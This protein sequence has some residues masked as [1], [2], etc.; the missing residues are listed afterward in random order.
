MNQVIPWVLVVA[1]W[2]STGL[3]KGFSCGYE[4]RGQVI[5]LALVTTKGLT[6]KWHSGWGMG[7][8]RWEMGDEE[9]N[10]KGSDVL[11]P[12]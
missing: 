4:W 5:M 7:D 9:G 1:Q 8:G 2:L 6:Q 12:G 10:K 11:I 3:H